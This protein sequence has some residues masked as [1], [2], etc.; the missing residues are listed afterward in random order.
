MK[1]DADSIKRRKEINNRIK[2]IVFI[3]LVIILY[4]IVLLYMS[5]IDKFDTPS[6]YIYK[7]YLISTES[8]EPEI[9]KGDAI[10]QGIFK[11]YLVVDDDTAEGERTGGFITFKIDEEVIT[12]RIVQIND[13]GTEKTYVTKGDNNNV[14]DHEILT[15]DDIEG[16][17]VMKI[18]YLGKVISGLKNGIVIDGVKC[19]PSRVKIRKHDVAKNTDLVEISIH[20]GR[21]H[22][23]KKL[24]KS[25]G[26]EVEKLKREKYAFLDLGTLQSGEY[27]YL[28]NKEVRKL[29]ALDKKK[30]T[31]RK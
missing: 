9:K 17:Q 22:I 12:H 2:K 8:M 18:P 24:F 4:N 16:K 14:E 1:Y 13:N 19:V 7:A 5:Y 28:D 30:S 10:G 21:N 26:H 27:R 29:Y 6:F 25:V 3:F 15:F 11:K 31:K 23:V 20:E